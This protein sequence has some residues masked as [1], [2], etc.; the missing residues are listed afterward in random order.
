MNDKNKRRLAKEILYFFFGIFCTLVLW[1]LIGAKNYLV[2]SNIEK[3]TTETLT[4]KKQLDSLKNINILDEYRRKQL[5]RNIS[6]MLDKGASEDDIKRM[7]TDYKKI[8][9]KK[10]IIVK[11]EQLEKSKILSLKNFDDTRKSLINNNQKT[12]ILTWGIF[13]IF[14]LIYPFR[15][16]YYS[17][18]WSIRTLKTKKQEEV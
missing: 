14:G 3:I 11:R 5:D 9:G 4:V 10:E 7:V 12:E 6:E 18:M 13:I 1:G 2:N 16:A 17:L 15:F 8:F